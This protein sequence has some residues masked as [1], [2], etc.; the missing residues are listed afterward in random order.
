MF[1]SE[2]LEVALGLA[3]LFS[4]M[5]L[6]ASA[7]RETLEAWFKQRGCAIL[8]DPGLDPAVERC[9]MLVFRSLICLPASQLRPADAYKA[10]A[11]RKACHSPE[12][13]R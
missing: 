1:G 11:R 12:P 9:S 6:F 5:S 2:T 4:F 3:V 7:F 13:A 8:I 10:A